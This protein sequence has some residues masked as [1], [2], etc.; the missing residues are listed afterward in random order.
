MLAVV[1]YVANAK[2]LVFLLN[3]FLMNA[4]GT[5][6]CITVRIFRK[7]LLENVSFDPTKHTYH[8]VGKCNNA[9]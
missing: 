8:N 6:C 9:P 2:K 5:F 3:N 7:I 4:I 1:R